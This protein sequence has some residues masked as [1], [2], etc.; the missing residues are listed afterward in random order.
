MK[1]LIIGG[2]GKIGQ[3]IISNIN[4]KE[5]EVFSI[6]QKTIIKDKKIKSYRFDYYK[7]FIKVRKL[8]TKYKF[9]V[10]IN[11]ICF[12]SNQV[13]RDYNLYKNSV[14]KY[15]FI[16]STSVYKN[17]QNV[18]LENSKTEITKNPYIVGKLKA[19]KF[20]KNNTKNFPYIILRICQIYGEDNI[21]T[22]FKKRSFTVLNDMYFNKR[23]FLPYGT[24]NNWKIIHVNDLAN[25]II[26]IFFSSNN[27]IKKN[28][29]NIVPDKTYSWNQIYNMYST[30]NKNKFKKILFDVKIL[31][32][33]NKEIYEH[34]ILDKLKNGNF[35]NKKIFKI[36]KKPR[37]NN[38][39][40]KIKSIV[41]IQKNRIINTT[42]D[43]DIK[44]IFQKLISLK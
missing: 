36:I 41:K 24:H 13:K 44:K 2:T 30:I 27:S 16:S 33:L 26:K 11:L 40:K 17:T 31:K 3:K 8:I 22:L 7:N 25:I 19:E 43:Q 14:S 35:S 39:E 4:L 38:F 21:P 10:V 32:N 12:N 28:I 6:S 1:I 9:D 23:I 5:H 20:L 34:L 37:F 15:L 18:I 29:F 42:P